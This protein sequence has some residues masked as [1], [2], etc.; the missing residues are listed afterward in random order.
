[1]GYYTVRLDP[2]ASKIFTIILPLGD[3]SYARLSMRITESSDIF[4]ANMSNHT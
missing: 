4:H 2:D 3:Y 1:M